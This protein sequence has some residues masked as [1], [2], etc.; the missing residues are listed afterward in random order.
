MKAEAWKE[1]GPRVRRVREAANIGLRELADGIG[2][3]ASTIS[4]FET[5][6]EVNLSAAFAICEELGVAM[7]GPDCNHEYACRFC[8]ALA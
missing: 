3:A 2:V 8:G 7:I 6:K 1:L 4:R 5:G